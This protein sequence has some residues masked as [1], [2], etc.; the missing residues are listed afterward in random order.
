[1]IE[2]QLKIFTYPPAGNEGAIVTRVEQE[3]LESFKKQ[4]TDPKIRI[5][6]IPT[7]MPERFMENEEAIKRNQ[8]LYIKQENIFGF[9]ITPI[10]AVAEIEQYRKERE[11]ARKEEEEAKKQQEEEAKKIKE[12]KELEQRSG[13]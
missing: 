2:Y 10:D 1:M 3:G 12:T 8:E 11:E 6:S 7:I 4:I 9:Y 5:I 13:K